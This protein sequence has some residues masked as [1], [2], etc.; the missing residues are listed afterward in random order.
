MSPA[1]SSASSELAAYIL[2]V[3]LA[4]LSVI[5]ALLLCK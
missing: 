5:G 2:A 4:M 1:V 3:A